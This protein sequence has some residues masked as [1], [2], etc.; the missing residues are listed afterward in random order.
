MLLLFSVT[1]AQEKLIY[2]NIRTDSKGNILPWY[3]DD[4]G[5]S[6]DHVINL[7]WNFWD[8]MRTDINSLPYY[9]NHQ[10]WK[11]G[12]NDA[13]GL[14]GDQFQMALSSWQLLYAY[15]GNER[16]KQNMKF[17]ADYYLT[18]SLSPANCKWPDL[19]FPYNTLIYSGIYDGDMVIGAG[20]LQPDKAGS[21]G[22][23]LV[24]LYKLSRGDFYGQS[25]SARYLDAAIKIARTL[26]AHLQPGDENHS[27]LPFKVNAFIG[28]TGKLKSN[29]I[30]G[31]VIGEAAYTTNWSGTMELFLALE[32]LDPE[33]A[34][35]YRNAFN[36]LLD[37]MK[38]YPLRNNRWG[39]FFEDVQ[40]WS[41]TQINA[42]TFARFMME[43]RQYFPGWQQQ[44][45]L[46]FDWVYSTLGNRNWEK[47]GVTVV[48]EQT[49]YQVPAQSHTSR[50]AAAELLYCALAKDTA[51][52]INAIRQLSWA[53]YMVDKDGKNRFPQDENWLTDGYGDYVRHYLRAMAACPELAPA[54]AD[55]ILSSTSVIQQADYKGQMNK[56]LVP[57][58]KADDPGKVRL[59]YRTFDSTGTETIRITQKPSQVLLDGRLMKEVDK[60]D[61]QGYRWIPL[62]KGGVLYI[63][64]LL[65]KEVTLLDTY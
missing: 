18:H 41:D 11:P 54:S 7:V 59:F 17:I 38:K 61:Q 42:M 39:P 23:E 36:L 44:V 47:Y 16:V 50:Q 14:G 52:K 49:V 1:Q 62:P 29:N 5:V 37:W 51:R 28:E 53:T 9:M 6:Y 20:Y 64:R 21:L 33:N 22:L 34:A 2:H 4:P 35:R 57:Y 13:R 19:P 48:N 63:R 10:V 32:Q 46:I 27:P 25:T 15:S 8:T 45:Q 60:G 40:G 65:G 24:H 26:T 31:T 43:Y 56:F 58:V 30:D 3:D 12:Y 55:H